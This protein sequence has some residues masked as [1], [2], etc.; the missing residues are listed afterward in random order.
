MQ[1]YAPTRLYGRP[2]DLCA[3]VDR[4]HAL[5][6]AVILDVVLNHLGPDGNYLPRSSI[7]SSF[8]P[9]ERPT[10]AT[11]STSS[12]RLASAQYFAECGAYGVDEFHLDGLRLDATHE[13]P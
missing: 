4:A 10:G 6:L 3:F 12:P 8:A 13:R 11:P 5:D 2:E 1:L 9:H 7:T